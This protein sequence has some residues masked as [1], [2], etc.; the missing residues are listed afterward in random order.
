MLPVIVASISY[1]PIPIFEVGPIQMSLH[2]IFAGIGFLA[3]G[4]TMMRFG[5][6]RGFDEGKIASALTW[7]LFGSILG[8]RLFTIPAHLGDPGF[9]LAEAFSLAGSYSIMGGFAGGILAGVARFRM[10]EMDPLTHL[11]LASFGL[12]VG[13]VVGRIGDLLIVEHL[14]GRTDFFLG[15][16]LKPGYEPAPQHGQLQRLCD[17]GQTCGPYHHAAMYDMVGA[18]VL[19]GFLW[20]LWRKAK[21]NYGQLFAAWVGWY[22]LQR[23]LI[24]FTRNSDLPGADASAGPL[25]WS[26]WSGL[27]LGLA[28]WAFYRWLSRRGE[29]VSPDSDRQRGAEAVASAR[30]G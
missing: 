30:S 8:A 29:P 6:S 21:L 11:D 10:L 3:G 13:T 18:L 20:M 23:F 15:Y 14:G 26:Q 7:G 5:R 25:T 16:L 19:I 4:Y 2:G 28:G 1:P 9:G 24:D 22:G 12:A 17:T 27:A